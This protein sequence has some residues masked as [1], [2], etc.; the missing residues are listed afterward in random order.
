[1][2]VDIVLQ[3][4]VT[5]AMFYV[6]AFAATMLVGNMLDLSVPDFASLLWRN[7][8][9]AAAPIVAGL[10]LSVTGLDG[11]FLIGIGLQLALITVV[12]CTFYEMDF[13]TE[14][15]S[16]VMFALVYWIAVMVIVFVLVATF[17]T[18]GV[19]SA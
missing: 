6:A 3:Y 2:H 7:A 17:F 12:L 1:M 5:F 19:A 10:I 4:G 15:K 13:A 16:I 14:W 11:S 9:L 18:A 8:I